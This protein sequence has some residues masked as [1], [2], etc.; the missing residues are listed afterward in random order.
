[1]LAVN[2]SSSPGHP[3]SALVAVE[4]GDTSQAVAVMD[5]DTYRHRADHI[6]T[7]FAQAVR[8]EQDSQR[9]VQGVQQ[10]LVQLLTDPKLKDRVD[11]QHAK[12]AELAEAEAAWQANALFTAELRNELQELAKQRDGDYTDEFK[13]SG[14]HSLDHCKPVPLRAEDI[15]P[16]RRQLV[17]EAYPEVDPVMG[18]NPSN[19]AVQL[20]SDAMRDAF[21][22]LDKARL[23]Y[24]TIRD[25]VVHLDAKGDFGMPDFAEQF[26]FKTL[27]TLRSPPVGGDK[28]V[29]AQ[30]QCIMLRWAML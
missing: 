9:R 29:F 5:Y 2:S 1:M 22:R 12:Q 10:D 6:K 20:T 30:F 7:H 4:R 16:R 21:E 8:V 28:L 24:I 14:L 13:F 25:L 27:R 19:P 18:F 15:S 23:G 26:V 11:L 17:R 3:G